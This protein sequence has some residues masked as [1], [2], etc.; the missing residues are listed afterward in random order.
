MCVCVCVCDVSPTDSSLHQEQGKEL[1]Q[2][3]C[4]AATQ[5]ELV[6]LSDEPAA[7]PTS[8]SFK[9]FVSLLCLVLGL[10]K[11]VTLDT[12]GSVHN[13]R[14]MSA[15]KVAHLMAWPPSTSGEGDGEGEHEQHILPALYL[16]F[17]KLLLADDLVKVAIGGGV[18][19]VH[20]DDLGGLGQPVPLLQSKLVWLLMND[21]SGISNLVRVRA[22][23]TQSNAV[24]FAGGGRRR[25][26]TMSVPRFISRRNLSL[27]GYVADSDDDDDM[28]DDDD[29]AP[30]DHDA[31]GL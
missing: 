14:L 23:D 19:G 5:A 18:F 22:P 27:W 26:V 2:L 6:I 13:Y 28:L 29:D 7:A 30:D 24:R 8:A 16:H 31:E 4:S 9:A 20:V 15:L 21:L 1:Q 10:G 3:L 11:D 25:D 12:I 17:Q